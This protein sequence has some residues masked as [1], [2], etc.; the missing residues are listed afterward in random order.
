MNK[1]IVITTINP[2][3]LAIKKFEEFNDWHII[4]VGDLKSKPIISTPTL[5]YLS[6]NDQKELNYEILDYLPYNHYARKTIGYLWAL[7]HDAEIIFDTDDDNTPLNSWKELEFLCDNEIKNGS[8][9]INIYKYFSEE[10]IWPRGYPLDKLND[11]FKNDFQILQ[12]MK[13]K[14]GCWQGVVNGDPD[15]DAIYRL[16]N[17][18]KINFLK[19]NPV[20]LP[21]NVFC[22]INSQ[23]TFWSKESFEFLLFPAH[24]S[25]RFTD[26]LRGYIAQKLLW[27][28][29]LHIGYHQANLYQDRNFHNTFNDF[30]EEIQ[31][32]ENIPK[33]LNLLS[34]M[35]LYDSRNHLLQVYENLVE[36][37]FLQ[38]DDLSLCKAWLNDYKNIKKNH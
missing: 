3:S 17:T 25:M 35:T 19:R 38:S 5:T 32:Y 22:P 10:K 8:N 21:L 20:N 34:S 9:F 15:F 11:S 33:I 30:L 24:V 16:T 1:F 7:E 31:M 6:I 27:E 37:N 12:T 18:E 14:I 4:I 23:N 13:K 36:H 28:K 26:I 29:N 2:K